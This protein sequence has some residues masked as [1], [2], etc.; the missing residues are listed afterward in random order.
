MHDS[1]TVFS[2]INDDYQILISPW[3]KDK[4]SYHSYAI[5][6]K[7][8]FQCKRGASFYHG[9]M[10]INAYL[11]LSISSKAPEPF[12]EPIP[13]M[14]ASRCLTTI[15]HVGFLK[16]IL[17]SILK[18]PFSHNPQ[19]VILRKHFSVFRGSI[20]K[21]NSVIISSNPFQLIRDIS[22]KARLWQLYIFHLLFCVSWDRL[23]KTISLFASLSVFPL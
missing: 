16:I 20:P 7:Q 8:F 14:E 1:W 5:G 23:C 17:E 4:V 6:D 18:R 11:S 21:P 19:T 2:S 3:S 9:T 10:Y 13:A 15:C 22:F 12:L